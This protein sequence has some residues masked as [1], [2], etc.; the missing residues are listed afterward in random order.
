MGDP[1][2]LAEV[3]DIFRNGTELVLCCVEGML[4]QLEAERDGYRKASL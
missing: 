2:L 4:E 3:A 1:G